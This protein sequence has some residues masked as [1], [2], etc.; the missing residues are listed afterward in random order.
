MQVKGKSVSD[1]QFVSDGPAGKLR[2]DVTA[3]SFMSWSEQE[4]KRKDCC[5][6]PKP[7]EEAHAMRAEAVCMSWLSD[8]PPGSCSILT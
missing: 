5:E 8:A 1:V 2:H 7:V 3:A 6:N 4:G